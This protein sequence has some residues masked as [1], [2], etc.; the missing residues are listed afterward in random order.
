MFWGGKRSLHIVKV[1]V[2]SASNSPISFVLT[3]TNLRY[4]GKT[5]TMLE[6]IY[7]VR[8]GVSNNRSISVLR[9]SSLR[10]LSGLEGE[11]QC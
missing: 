11:Q 5:D 7:V 6:V 9:C 3:T 4:T 1:F 2:A 10:V 8:H